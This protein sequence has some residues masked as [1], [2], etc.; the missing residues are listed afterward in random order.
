MAIVQVPLPPKLIPVFTPPRG[1]LR[2]R[3]AYGGRASGKSFS[4]AEMASVFGLQDPLRI[5]CAREYQNS[6]KESFHA[7]LKNAINSKPWLANA[8]DVGVDYIRGKNGTEFLFKGLRQNMS[9][10]KSMSGIDI[11][12][13]EEAEDVPEFSWIDLEPT[14]RKKGSE[15]WVIWN[16]KKNGSPT[17]IRFKKNKPERSMIVE[18]NW[19]DNPA[20]PKVM[21]EQ[22][23]SNE[24]TM[25]RATYLHIWEGNYLKHSAAQIFRDKYRVEEFVPGKL[26]DGPYHG[27]D[28][29][30]SQDPTAAV[31]VWVFD[32]R[33]WIEYEAGKK[34]LE[35]DETGEFIRNGIPGIENYV[36]RAD[37][38]RPESISYVK[39]HGLPLIEGVDKWKGSV[40]D[41]IEHIKSYKEVIIHPRC[42]KTLK[43]FDSYSFRVDRLS[44]DILPDILDENNHYIDATRYAINPLIK[45]RFTNY[46][47]IL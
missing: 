2:Y 44:Q 15:I 43:E 10:I 16:P 6:I 38:A 34:G 39:R 42:P 24:K 18:I 25:D 1:E 23:R 30:F 28:W 22:R 32:N 29:G 31:K 13:I 19:R 20:F 45:S 47:G 11:C 9:S 33:L 26:W 4:F 12:I 14:I 40:E 7:E 3:G 27:L 21:D 36:T 46:K 41:G 35:L 17:D 37:N 8:Y 5:L